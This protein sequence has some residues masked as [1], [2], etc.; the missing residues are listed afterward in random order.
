MNPSSGR[1]VSCKPN[2]SM[3]SLFALIDKENRVLLSNHRTLR[4]AVG[5]KFKH[6]ASIRREHGPDAFAIY[7]IVGPDEKQY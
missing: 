7:S 5:A 1:T 2:P 3:F 4:G 6:L